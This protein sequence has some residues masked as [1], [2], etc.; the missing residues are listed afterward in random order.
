MIAIF[1][2][3]GRFLADA[4]L[5]GE[6]V[7]AGANYQRRCSATRECRKPTLVVNVGGLPV[8][9]YDECLDHARAQPLQAAT[10]SIVRAG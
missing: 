5:R 10:T 7:S 1:Q 8:A 6:K 2:S 4:A 3:T 9:E